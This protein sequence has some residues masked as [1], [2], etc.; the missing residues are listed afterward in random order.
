VEWRRASA[1][2]V[3]AEAPPP[4]EEVDPTAGPVAQISDVFEP[5]ADAIDPARPRLLPIDRCLAMYKDHRYAEVVSLGGAALQVH[6]RMAAV[7][8]RPDEAAALQDLVGLSKQE[9]G[10]REGARAA[11]VAAIAAAAPAVR[12][13]Y[14]RHLLAL[15]RGVVDNVNVKDDD[16]VR[17]RELLGCVRTIDEALTVVPGNEPLTA[18]VTSV[19]Q[20]LTKLCDTLV[21]RAVEDEGDREARDLVLQVL[22]E[23]SMPVAWQEKLRDRLAAV[24]SAEVGQLTAQA[25]RAVQEGKDTE[26]LDALEHAE[27][28]AA[29]LPAGGVADERREELDR[30]LWWGYTKVGLRRVETRKFEG[31]LEPLF[32]A[33]ELGGTDG[34]RIEETRSALVRA[35]DGL[36]D[37]K[38]P[39]I[40]NLSA[41]D[42]RAAHAEVEKLWAVLRNAT[43]RGMT[44]DDLGEA[45]GKI[46]HLSQTLTQTP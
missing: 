5:R 12:P 42:P 2:I 45:F 39:L 10:D 46:M 24:S 36:V 15:V 41:A 4:A 31:A 8:E 30:R 18:G 7:S 17:V 25:I 1:P 35:L 14:V 22:A 34:E 43:E 6:A 40:Q 13:T 23:G 26:A 28:L 44:Q 9:M 21:A 29:S 19:R 16:G 33:F 37:L 38:R 27:R 11:F 3:P 20:A 32:R